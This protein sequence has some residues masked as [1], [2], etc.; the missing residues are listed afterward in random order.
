VGPRALGR[1]AKARV[2]AI[3]L[4]EGMDAARNAAI[5]VSGQ[6]VAPTVALYDVRIRRLN[7]RLINICVL[8]CSVL[9]RS[10]LPAFPADSPLRRSCRRHPT[11][12]ARLMADF[13][14]ETNRCRHLSILVSATSDWDLQASPGPRAGLAHSV[15]MARSGLGLSRPDMPSP[16][17][18]GFCTPERMETLNAPEVSNVDG[19]PAI[20]F[21]HAS[22]NSTIQP[23]SSHGC[24][25]VPTSGIH[26]GSKYGKSYPNHLPAAKDEELH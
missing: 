2:G 26:S 25:I 14:L 1:V 23:R 4:L 6:C 8:S 18:L 16:Q 22:Q 7:R 9:S 17:E 11:I 13:Y 15:S 19:G 3:L 20:T 10:G 12:P 24:Y 21:L 5:E